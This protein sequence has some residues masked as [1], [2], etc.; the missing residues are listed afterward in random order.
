MKKLLAI[1]ALAFTAGCMNL[2]TRAPWTTSQRIESCY[3]SSRWV[4]GVG[5]I[6]MFPQV[7]SDCPGDGGF[8][9]ENVFT[10]PFGLLVE[11]EAVVEAAVDTV[12]LPFDWPVS[13]YRRRERERRRDEER[14]E[15]VE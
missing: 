11:C 1:A 8:V 15:V 14:E 4:A 12:C 9:F 7:M 2:C 5:L 10:I 3:Q 6:C 13:A